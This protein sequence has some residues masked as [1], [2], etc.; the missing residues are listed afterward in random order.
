MR[1][2]PLNFLNLSSGAVEVGKMSCKVI[3]MI[4]YCYEGDIAN[5]TK[6]NK[7]T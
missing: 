1:G 7:K 3:I 4:Q 5:P 6:L 2:D